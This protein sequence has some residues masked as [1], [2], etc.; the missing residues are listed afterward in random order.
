[1]QRRMICR[2]WRPPRPTSSSP[3]GRGSWITLAWDLA[4][5]GSLEGRQRLGEV[6]LGEHGQRGDPITEILRRGAPVVGE[7]DIG[8]V[9]VGREV[10]TPEPTTGT[11]VACVVEHARHPPDRTVLVVHVDQVVRDVVATGLHQI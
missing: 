6:A 3:S 2:P 5:D 7:G 4:G 10:V 8:P 11:V 9:P 1:M